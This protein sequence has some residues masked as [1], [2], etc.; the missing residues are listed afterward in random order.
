MNLNVTPWFRLSGGVLY[1]HV[2]GVALDGT[3]SA[4]LSGASLYLM[5]RFGR[6][7]GPRAGTLLPC[8]LALVSVTSSWRTSRISR[9]P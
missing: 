5:L 7:R 2:G 4:E 6:F 1:Q 3:S 8:E 9:P